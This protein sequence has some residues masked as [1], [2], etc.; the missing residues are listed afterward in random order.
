MRVHHVN[1]GTMCPPFASLVNGG[2]SMFERGRMVCHCLLVESSEGLVLVDTGLGTGDVETP[3]RRLGGGFVTL[4]RP[5]LDHRET[6]LA[7]VERLGFR[8]SD[9]RHIVPTHLDLDHAGGLSDFPDA[10]VHVHAREKAAADARATVGERQRYRP[11][12]FAHGPRWKQYDVGAGG[13][14]WFGFER[15]R[16]AIGTSDEILL[17]PL[18]GHT[19]GH[20]GIAVKTPGGWLL[21]AGDAYFSH[22]EVHAAPP[23]S[24]WGLSFFQSRAEIDRGSRLANQV[25]LRELARTRGADVTVFSAHDPTELEDA[26]VSVERMAAAEVEEE[27]PSRPTCLRST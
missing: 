27:P 22:G 23:R 4:L 1:C 25:R 9:V 17:V 7:H 6:A 18:F 12:H 13:D 14:T 5:T 21:H 16:A 19:R 8:R 26:S 24:P 11:L 2:G 20:C 3:R 15:V 10:T